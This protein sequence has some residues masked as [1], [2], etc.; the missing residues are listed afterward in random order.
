MQSNR[1]VIAVA[2]VV[3]KYCYAEEL[4]DWVKGEKIADAGGKLLTVAIRSSSLAAVTYLSNYGRSIHL[5]FQ[6]PDFKIREVIESI[7]DK[8]ATYRSGQ[9]AIQWGISTS[10]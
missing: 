3:E 6:G 1:D 8:K 4:D 5:F 9:F 10:N 2:G 7:R